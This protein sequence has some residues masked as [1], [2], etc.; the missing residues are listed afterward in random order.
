MGPLRRLF[1]GIVRH[2]QRRRMIRAL[3][4]MDDRLLRDIGL[5]RGDIEAV[6]DSFDDRELQMV[7]LAPAAL[8]VGAS[9][10]ARGKAA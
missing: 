4:A 5:A 3:Q 9:H 1:G 2:W 6:V 8:A 7:P 10:Q